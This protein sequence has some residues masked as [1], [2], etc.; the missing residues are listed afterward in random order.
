MIAC[1]YY[2]PLKTKRVK[3][4]SHKDIRSIEE[5]SRAAKDILSK[6][7]PA[8]FDL[9]LQNFFIKSVHLSRLCGRNGGMKR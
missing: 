2:G 6:A 9:L 5:T 3:I 4:P 8:D 1:L 7:Q